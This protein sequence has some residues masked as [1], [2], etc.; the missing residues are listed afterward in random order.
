MSQMRPSLILGLNAGRGF[1]IHGGRFGVAL[2]Q[3]GL[4]VILQEE[5]LKVGGFP[6]GCSI[7][8]F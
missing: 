3:V 2:S 8:S 7:L 5:W 4:H 6:L 1:G